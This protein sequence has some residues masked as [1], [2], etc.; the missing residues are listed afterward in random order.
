MCSITIAFL[1][2]STDIEKNQFW[3][4]KPNSH[5]IHDSVWEINSWKEDTEK[6]QN[7]PTWSEVD[8]GNSMRTQ[9]KFKGV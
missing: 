9:Y 3:N 5:K 7:R 2:S 8:S 1:S 4:N 6:V